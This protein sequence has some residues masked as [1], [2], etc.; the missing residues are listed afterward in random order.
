MPRTQS[1]SGR[2]GRRSNSA[3]A[4]AAEEELPLMPSDVEAAAASDQSG[5]ETF[6]EKEYPTPRQKAAAGMTLGNGNTYGTDRQP[7]RD[8]SRYRRSLTLVETIS[9]ITLAWENVNVFAPVIATD[10]C[11]RAYETDAR[12]Q[13]LHGVTGVAK[14]GTL[15]A[16]LGAS[17]AGKSTLLNVLT[18]RNQSSLT[19][20]GSV[21]VN[22]LS[23]D[24]GIKALSAYV[25]QDD[26]FIGTL[27]VREHLWFQALLRMES[28]MSLQDRRQRVEEV[29]DE[30]G[31]VKCAEDY[32]GNP[33]TRKGISGGEMK[34][35]SFASEL[36]TNPPLMFCDEPTSG[37]DSYMAE[38]V[39]RTL[40]RLA[41]NGRTI[42][43]TIHQPSSESFALFDQ[44]MLMAE[45]RVAYLG[46]AS[47]A[48]GFFADCGYPCPANFNPADHFVHALAVRAGSEAECRQRVDQLAVTFAKSALAEAVLEAV[49]CRDFCDSQQV[50]SVASQLTGQSPY[51]AS[52][53]RQVLALLWRCWLAQARDANVFAV[54]ILQ[55]IVVAVIVA[56]VYF[57]QRYD[58]NGVMNLN[59]AL[60]LFLTNTT[61]SNFYTVLNSFPLELPIFFREH[62]NGMYRVDAYFLCKNLA[63]TP[64]FLLLPFSFTVV[65]YW[66]IGLERSLPAFLMALLVVVLICKSAVSLAYFVATA[67]GR[68]DIALAVS[69]PAI[70][71]FLLL[72]GFFL[73][74][75]SIPVWLD[76]LR[77]LSWFSYGYETLVV[78]QWSRVANI[79]CPLDG[80]SGR[81]FRTGSDVIESL[82]FSAERTGFN[83]GMLC[84]LILGLRLLAFACLWLRA[85]E[86][87]RN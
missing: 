32:I 9:S 51:R 14:P 62:H 54:R 34:R 79:S 70:L 56:A 61:F 17:G 74:Q 21:K 87:S 65:I 7:S 45:G 4:A 31:L 35:L 33:G 75:A 36:L 77:Y 26:M 50:A 53:S 39:V 80:S 48:L 83:L 2:F 16:I 47:D 6:I 12:K 23:V 58:Q 27:K 20:Q 68:I 13:I 67:S 85:R 41:A 84:A 30:M 28:K 19:I 72:G 78:N 40:R 46:P 1:S 81:C 18:A 15:L 69:N 73:N 22:G 8:S 44:L 63:E 29:L 66:A 5:Y 24:K 57:D 49:R 64:L 59:G 52:W 55:T 11:G 43:C 76:W 25:Q 42:L 3:A 37:L 82:N 71:P 60:F 38:T 86:K 10:C